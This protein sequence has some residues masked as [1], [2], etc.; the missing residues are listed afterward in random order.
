M[1]RCVVRKDGLTKRSDDGFFSLEIGETH[2]F[3]EESVN[4]LEP[5]GVIERSAEQKDPDVDVSRA[6]F[7]KS[8]KIDEVPE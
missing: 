4:W 3:S 8:R 5:Q 6:G 1:I 2:E 7:R